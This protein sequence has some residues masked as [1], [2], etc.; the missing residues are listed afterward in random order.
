V[1]EADA[2]V[3]GAGAVP[4]TMLAKSAGLELGES[5]G[6]R[7]DSRLATAVPGVFAAG[8]VAEY[9]SVIHGGRQIRV[10]HWDVA[11]QHGRTVAANML[12]ADRPHD[13]VPYFFSDIADWASLEY[14]GPAE[15]WDREVLRGSIGDGVFAI[16]YLE[17]ERVVAALSVGRGEDLAHARRFIAEGTPVGAHADA[18]ADPDTDLGTL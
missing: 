5:G 13:A 14:V 16:F 6:I 8:D 17:R 3:I 10:E 9:A 4:D 7:V 15:H 18:L 1:L 12:G 2:V 11:L